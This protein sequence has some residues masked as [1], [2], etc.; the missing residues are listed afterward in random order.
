[1]DKNFAID[2]EVKD[3]DEKIKNQRNELQ[4]VLN[5][6]LCRSIKGSEFDEIVQNEINKIKS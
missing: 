2:S 6:G 1:M 5:C 3:Y 4:Q